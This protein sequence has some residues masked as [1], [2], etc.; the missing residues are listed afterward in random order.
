MVKLPNRIC[1]S[2]KLWFSMEHHERVSIIATHLWG[3]FFKWSSHSQWQ[4]TVTRICAHIYMVATPVLYHWA[5]HH[6]CDVM[7]LLWSHLYPLG[8][9]MGINWAVNTFLQSWWFPQHP[10]TSAMWAFHSCLIKRLSTLGCSC[11]W[12]YSP[13][14]G[15]TDIG[16]LGFEQ[17]SRTYAKNCVN[18]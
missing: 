8:R 3:W 1:F 10:N 15:H 12:S 17:T 2:C 13:D 7:P 4:T 18:V 5:M 6:Y 16:L 14:K 11:N 9:I